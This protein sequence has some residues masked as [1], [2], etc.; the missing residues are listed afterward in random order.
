MFCLP[1]PWLRAF[2]IT[3]LSA[4]RSFKYARFFKCSFSVLQFLLI[5]EISARLNLMSI[6]RSENSNCHLCWELFPLKE[7][8]HIFY[9]TMVHYRFYDVENYTR[10]R[11]RTHSLFT[12]PHSFLW[13]KEHDGATAYGKYEDKL[14]AKTD[15]QCGNLTWADYVL[16]HVLYMDWLWRKCDRDDVLRHM[17]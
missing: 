17:T 7:G 5:F 10:R 12:P 15:Y 2:S 6:V 4:T 3:E 9:T 14:I 8:W 1:G 11:K 13:E 16:E